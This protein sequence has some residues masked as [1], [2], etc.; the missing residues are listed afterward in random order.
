MITDSEITLYYGSE[1]ISARVTKDHV[2]ISFNKMSVWVNEKGC[3]AST[4]VN[5]APDPYD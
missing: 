1:Q 4:P 2:H 5:T 3:F